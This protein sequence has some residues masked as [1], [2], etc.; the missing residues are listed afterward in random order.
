MLPQVV[1]VGAVSRHL[2]VVQDDFA[3]LS[4]LVCFG[5]RL[6]PKEAIEAAEESLSV[7]LYV[8]FNV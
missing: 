5:K 7:S 6:R 4:V 2:S 8:R 1:M 3:G